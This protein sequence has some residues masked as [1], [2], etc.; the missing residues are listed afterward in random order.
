MAFA[1]PSAR[2]DVGGDRRAR[3]T[4]LAEGDE[5]YLPHVLID[6]RELGYAAL[7]TRR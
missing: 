2:A 5:R 4:A 1:P 6:N 7:L 3:R